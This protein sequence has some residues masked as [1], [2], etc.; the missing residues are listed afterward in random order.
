MAID[1]YQSNFNLDLRLRNSLKIC[2][3]G[4]NLTQNAKLLNKYY[5]SVIRVTD[6]TKTEATEYFVSDSNKNQSK[7]I[8]MRLHKNKKPTQVNFK[9]YPPRHLKTINKEEVFSEHKTKPHAFV[10]VFD[11]DHESAFESIHEYLNDLRTIYSK[12]AFQQ[13]LRIAQGQEVIDQVRVRN[14]NPRATAIVVPG[15]IIDAGKYSVKD[16]ILPIGIT[17]ESAQTIE[18]CIF[19]VCILRC[20]L[21]RYAFF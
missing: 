9:L 21:L 14:A 13:C 19:V 4:D 7:M 6:N 16:S 18:L 1:P 10:I 2:F 5:N 3:L 12:Q 17:G 8:E 11:V 20:V 15:N